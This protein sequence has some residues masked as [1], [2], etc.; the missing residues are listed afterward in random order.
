MYAE[1]G[2][3]TDKRRPTELPAGPLIAQ[4]ARS[5][6]GQ[7]LTVT[8]QLAFEYESGSMKLSVAKLFDG[9][10]HA[11]DRACVDPGVTFIFTNEGANPIKIIG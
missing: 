4:L 5:F 11:H 2:S 3:I 6:Q 1:V 10:G 8:Q 9:N 7:V